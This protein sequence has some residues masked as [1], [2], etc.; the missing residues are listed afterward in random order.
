MKSGAQ[1]CK[2]TQTAT[3]NSAAK[4][5]KLTEFF[6]ASIITSTKYN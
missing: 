2:R 1:K 6:A 5:R 4:S 3:S